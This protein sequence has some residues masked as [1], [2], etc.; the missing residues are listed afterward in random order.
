MAHVEN[1][2]I[3]APFRLLDFVPSSVIKMPKKVFNPLV[4]QGPDVTAIFDLEVD[5]H[6]SGLEIKFQVQQEKSPYE[7]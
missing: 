4:L 5:R 6:S 3:R 7:P 2:Q 1:R